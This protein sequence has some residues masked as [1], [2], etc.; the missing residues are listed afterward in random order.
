MHI[1]YA[2]LR[3]HT[4]GLCEKQQKIYTWN[5]EIKCTTQREIRKEFLRMTYSASQNLLGI[6]SV[7]NSARSIVVAVM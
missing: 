2:L 4:D 3:I 1:L 7:S 6:S 5:L